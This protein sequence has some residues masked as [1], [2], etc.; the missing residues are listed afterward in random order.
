MRMPLLGM[1]IVAAMTAA[2]YAQA[3]NDRQPNSSERAEIGRVLHEAGFKS[4]GK[5]ELDDGKWEVDDARRSDH[6]R[7]EVH[8]KPGTLEVMKVKRDD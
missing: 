1:S 4:W 2:G 3:G 8:L 5:I 6:R 7:Y